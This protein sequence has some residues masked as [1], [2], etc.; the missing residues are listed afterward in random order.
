MTGSPS[1]A[2]TVVLQLEPAVRV[3][4]IARGTAR[5]TIADN[6]PLVSIAAADPNASETDP[7]G[8]GAGRFIVRRTGSLANL[9]TVKFHVR[10]ASTADAGADFAPLPAAINIPAG[11][12]YA[13]INVTPVDDDVQEERESVIVQLDTSPMYTRATRYFAPVRIEDNEAPRLG[14]VEQRLALP[15]ADLRWCRHNRARGQGRR[16]GGELHAERWRSFTRA[17]RSSRT[18][19]ASSR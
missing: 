11:R 7:T 5:V 19:S 17:A 10:G 12:A 1:A 4:A 16:A 15:R 3:H 8:A 18:R 14:V 9:L 6:E 13:Y 2:K